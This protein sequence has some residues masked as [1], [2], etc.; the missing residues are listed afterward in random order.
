[1]NSTST[2]EIDDPGS[3][4]ES[5]YSDYEELVREIPTSSPSGL[6]ALNRSFHK[7]LLVASASN[8]EEQ[9]KDLIPRLFVNHGRG[10]MGTF[11][12]RRVLA[13][14]YA[15]LFEWKDMKAQ[16][17][18]SSFGDDAGKDFKARLREDDAF[19]A[20]HDAFMRLGHLRNE[21]VHNDYALFNVELTPSEIVKLFRRACQFVKE[22]EDMIFPATPAVPG[23][24]E[25]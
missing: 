20:D 23:L 1:M 13:R 5:L 10:E 18:F 3:A 17:F 8:L 21:V 24:V 12:F 2:V 14:G 25:T 11:V 22:I 9:V 7:H 19:R 4:V 6:S 15:G 16:G